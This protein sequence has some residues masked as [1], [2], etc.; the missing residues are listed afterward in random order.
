MRELT[1]SGHLAA[2]RAIGPQVP[3]HPTSAARR[4]P[5][6]SMI[7]TTFVGLLFDGGGV[8]HVLGE[9][10][11]PTLEV[12]SP[13]K[14]GH[15]LDVVVDV[16]IRQLQVEVL[17]ALV[18]VHDIVWTVA[19]HLVGHRS[20][21]PIDVLRGHRIHGRKPSDVPRAP[22]VFRRHVECREPVPRLSPPAYS[23]YSVDGGWV[24]VRAAVSR[25]ADS[26]SGRL[27]AQR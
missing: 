21:F 12:D 22:T 8:Q 18:E 14:S 13:R 26:S 2:T 1:R 6:A 16:R 7:A 20:T 10:E 23:L 17:E 3:N 5:T 27:S 15:P 19:D 25:V 11:A 24:Q 4:I 9:A